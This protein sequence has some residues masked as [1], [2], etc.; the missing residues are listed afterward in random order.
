MWECKVRRESVCRVSGKEG[1]C[2]RVQ[3][4]EGVCLESVWV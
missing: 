4:K 1:E 2:V 3:G